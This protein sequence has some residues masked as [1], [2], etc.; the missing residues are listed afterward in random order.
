M[1]TLDQNRWHVMA[2]TINPNPNGGEAPDNT[3]G[4]ILNHAYSV[5]Q[6]KEVN[7]AGTPR[8]LL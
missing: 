4:L 6:F 7:D 3:T 5:L 8:K 1:H 2:A